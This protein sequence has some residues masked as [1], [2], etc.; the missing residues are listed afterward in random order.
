MQSNGLCIT[1]YHIDHFT[2]RDAYFDELEALIKHVRSSRISP[3]VGEILLP[4]D[5]EC[6]FRTGRTGLTD[7]RSLD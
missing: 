4:G 6:R 3:N 1:A 2:N 7:T 5:P